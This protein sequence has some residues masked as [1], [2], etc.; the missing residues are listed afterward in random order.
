[1]LG[2]GDRALLG[3]GS[4]AGGGV[5]QRQRVRCCCDEGHRPGAGGG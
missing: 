5:P 3:L 1:M 4:V 2:R